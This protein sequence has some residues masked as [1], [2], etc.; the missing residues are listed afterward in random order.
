LSHVSSPNVNIFKLT[1]LFGLLCLKVWLHSTCG[2][3]CISVGQHWQ[4]AGFVASY[5]LA[6]K[7]L[8]QGASLDPKRIVSLKSQSSSTRDPRFHLTEWNSPILSWDRIEGRQQLCLTCAKWYMS[9][10]RGW[11]ERT[12]FRELVKLELCF[13]RRMKIHINSHTC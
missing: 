6:W 8:K 11:K 4:M 5:L 2:S 10:T 7:C 3:H 9:R 1:L 12:D 13:V